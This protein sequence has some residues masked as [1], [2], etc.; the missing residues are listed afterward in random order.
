ML[1]KYLR[2]RDY[3][4]FEWLLEK[5]DLYYRPRPYFFERVERKK[6]MARDFV[7]L[8]VLKMFSWS[9]PVLYRV[10]MSSGFLN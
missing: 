8:L 2:E 4:K 3:K 9:L 7:L 6:H 10:V 5:L 1:L